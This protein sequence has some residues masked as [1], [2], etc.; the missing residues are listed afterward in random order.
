MFSSMLRL[1]GPK[2]GEQ[3]SVRFL[4]RRCESTL[5]GNDAGPAKQKKISKKMSRVAD[6]ALGKK[7]SSMGL[8]FAGGR[9]K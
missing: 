8:R 4:C 6:E 7:T 5:G 9:R 3:G 2:D 1:C